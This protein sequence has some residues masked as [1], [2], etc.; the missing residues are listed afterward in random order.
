MVGMPAEG[1]SRPKLIIKN[2][3]VKTVDL[4]NRRSLIDR[5]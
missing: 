3:G 4:Q 5:N 2:G 1:L